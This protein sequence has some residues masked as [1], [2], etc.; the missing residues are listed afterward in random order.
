M[1]SVLQI[2]AVKLEPRSSLVITIAQQENRE[3]IEKILIL[4]K[5]ILFIMTLQG[6]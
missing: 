5:K 1:A 6:M 3:F 4:E 2:T